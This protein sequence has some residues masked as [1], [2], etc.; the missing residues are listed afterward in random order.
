MMDDISSG[1]KT[2]KGLEQRENTEMMTKIAQI[3]SEMHRSKSP[4]KLIPQFCNQFSLLFS[5]KI[6]VSAKVIIDQ[7]EYRSKKF[8]ETGTQRS[9]KRG[10]YRLRS[11]AQT[12]KKR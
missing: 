3:I 10:S 12:G 11:V 4:E 6:P 8:V 2:E 1:K 9:Y 5:E 7:S